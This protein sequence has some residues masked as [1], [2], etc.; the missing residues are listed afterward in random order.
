MHENTDEKTVSEELF[1]INIFK[2]LF[3]FPQKEKEHL[4]TLLFQYKHFLMLFWKVFI[5]HN[6]F[7]HFSINDGEK[8][9]KNFVFTNHMCSQ[10]LVLDIAWTTNIESVM[11][12][13][14]FLKNYFCSKFMPQ[15]FF[16]FQV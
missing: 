11:W 3:Y 8:H 12:V 2:N 4:K 9:V 13:N 1:S 15:D 6:I 5:S 10:A 14:K 7:C 16:Y